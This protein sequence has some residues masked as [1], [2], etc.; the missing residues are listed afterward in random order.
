MEITQQSRI[1][2]RKN[3]K[4]LEEDLARR[5][6]LIKNKWK[7]ILQNE[8][9][10]F[11]QQVGNYFKSKSNRFF[12]ILSYEKPSVYSDCGDFNIDFFDL[13]DKIETKDKL[14]TC[15][16][17]FRCSFEIIK[18]NEKEYYNVLRQNGGG[19]KMSITNRERK[20]QNFRKRI[21]CA[22]TKYTL[23]V[24]L[25]ANTGINQKTCRNYVERME[26]EFKEQLK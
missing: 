26:T 7:K 16:N 5:R 13:K 9:L 25:I 10:F 3:I 17:V 8:E 21:L 19:D 23:D 1:N 18:I 15:Y 4:L 12:K 2:A 20:Y 11:S 14:T 22:L 24:E 6:L